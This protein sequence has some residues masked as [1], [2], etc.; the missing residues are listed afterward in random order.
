MLGDIGKFPAHVITQ[1]NGYT[2]RLPAIVFLFI[3]SSELSLRL[4]ED[5]S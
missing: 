2:L 1:Q 3:V 4:V 5:M